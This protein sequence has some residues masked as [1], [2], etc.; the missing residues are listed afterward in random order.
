MV[1]KKDINKKEFL[2]ELDGMFVS[3]FAKLIER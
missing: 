2:N 1:E 3:S